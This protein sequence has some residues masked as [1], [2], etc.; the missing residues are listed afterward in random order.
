[1]NKHFALLLLLASLALFV[2][3]AKSSGKGRLPIELEGITI[4]M[5]EAEVKSKLPGVRCMD[6]KGAFSDRV[7]Y[8]AGSF[9]PFLNV[10]RSFAGPELDDA[11]CRNR[12]TRA[13]GGA[14]GAGI[15]ASA[16]GGP[17]GFGTAKIS[18]EMRQRS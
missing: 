7:C 9:D 14:I 4:G 12:V 13:V 3:P 5:S 6:R 15:T 18:R 10:V 8:D 17:R 11:A 1:M 2:L 16:T